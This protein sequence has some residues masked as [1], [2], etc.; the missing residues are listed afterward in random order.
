MD[1]K[2]QTGRG[3]LIVALPV[4]THRR[5]RHGSIYVSTGAGIASPAD[6]AGR[7]VVIG[8]YG[9]AAAIW[10]GRAGSRARVRHRAGDPPTRNLGF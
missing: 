4:F 1:D 8:G 6:L 7:S 2:G 3:H 5:F 9:A 10:Q